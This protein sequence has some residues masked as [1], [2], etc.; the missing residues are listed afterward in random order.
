MTTKPTSSP[1]A[2]I[3]RPLLPE[4]LARPRLFK[5][6][7]RALRRSIVWVSGPAGAGKTTLVASYLAAAAGMIL[8]YQVDGSDTDPEAF[9]FYLSLAVGHLMPRGKTPIPD[10]SPKKGSVIPKKGPGVEVFTRHYIHQLCERL[11]KDCVLVFDNYQNVPLDSPFHEA[12]RNLLDAIPEGCRVIAISRDAPPPSLVRL[13]ANQEMELIGGDLLRA[14]PQETR[15]IVQLKH[16]VPEKT[17]RALYQTTGG[18]I[19]GIILMIQRTN[20]FKSR[21][22]VLP[23]A[24]TKEVVDYFSR[25]VFERVDPDVQEFLMQTA[26]YDRMTLP[27]VQGLTHMQR[28]GD[29]LDD[30]VGRA[31]FIEKQGEGIYAIYQYH[32]LFRKFLLRRAE[33][34]STPAL[35]ARIRHRAAMQL[36][37]VGQIEDAVN[38]YRTGHHWADVTRLIV[39][40]AP[41]LISQGRYATV[42]AWL[43]ALPSSV[44][45]ED[46]WLVYWL[47]ACRLHSDL[48]S[49]RDY[50]ERAFRQFAQRGDDVGSLLAWSGVVESIFLGP[51]DLA[52]LDD[53]LLWLEERLWNKPAF[54]SVEIEA[55]IVCNLTQILLYRRM[56]HPEIRNW[57]ERS[58]A[59]A[60]KCSSP[61]L[62]LQA[63][64][65]VLH[66]FVWTG[67]F[68]LARETMLEIKKFQQM[69]DVA[70]T[71][72]IQHKAREANYYHSV[73]AN[74][75]ALTLQVISEAVEIGQTSG[76]HQWDQLLYAQGVYACMNEGD[77]KSAGEFLEKMADAINHDLPMNICH[78]YYLSTLLALCRED[79]IQALHYAEKG[80]GM[81]SRVGAQFPE[82][83]FNLAMARALQANGK[84]IAAARYLTI[85]KNMSRRFG[86]MIL[87]YAVLLSEAQF[88]FAAASADS[89][90]NGLKALRE[91]MKIGRKEEYV[92]VYGWYPKL[93][94]SL[95]VKALENNIEPEYVS[96]LIRVHGLFPEIPATIECEL[97]PWPI[98]IYTLGRFSI[99]R[100]GVPLRF[101]RRGQEKVIEL[102]KTLIAMRG[103]DVSEQ[104]LTEA[105]W[106]ETDGDKAHQRFKTTAHRLRKLLG[107]DEVISVREGQVTLDPRSCWVD[108]YA[109]ERLLGRKPNNIAAAEKAL[110]LYQGRFLE[111]AADSL[112]VMSLRERL[113]AKYLRRLSELGRKLEVSREWE[114]ATS[115]YQQGLGVDPLV[116]EY[117]QRLMICHQRRGHR[118]EAMSVYLR[119]N[120]TLRRYLGIAPS[121]ETE[122]IYRSIREDGTSMEKRRPPGKMEFG[123]Y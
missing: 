5:L 9:F 16:R 115:C 76:V 96:S 31:Y 38:M 100:D 63:V 4:V 103:R 111:N 83:A 112:W 70:P 50:F 118:A 104:R 77:L 72:L 45:E 43:S 75:R 23:D 61:T 13:R 42:E 30:L 60:R 8:W 59:L 47:G 40:H 34:T 37:K 82:A 116:E 91:A 86:T 56:D 92:T 109:F 85:A 19:A 57:M 79:P 80:I 28:G 99:V 35:L 46:T 101:E 93:M 25:E 62:R 14:T 69:H 2:K 71:V 27:L 52:R 58:M 51:D 98:R 53:W 90:S 64:S 84:S 89:E 87:E 94:A 49:S 102:L 54:P 81:V 120:E 7:K 113:H 114:R 20:M 65:I 39:Q 66:Y 88:A 55:R 26:F 44:I 74:G 105:L 78:F 21:D 6:L 123:K 33:E 41:L 48:P 97:W 106:P 117:Y 1:I 36:E 108:V 22:D 119:C 122:A 110:A 68:R 11:P 24:L 32:P 29:I 3:T 15:G 67:Q 17:I 121:P 95:C 12:M 73:L 18:W 10:L 107:N